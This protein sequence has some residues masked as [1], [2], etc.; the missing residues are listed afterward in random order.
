MTKY[1]IKAKSNERKTW[2]TTYD[3]ERYLDVKTQYISYEN[4]LDDELIHFSKYDCDRSIPK[5]MD[6]LNITKKILF[7]AF[8]KLYQEIKVAQ[9]WICFRTI[10]ISLRVE[11]KW[12]DC[13]YGTRFCRIKQYQSI[14]TKRS[15]RYA[16][17]IGKDGVERYIFTKLNDITKIFRKK[18][19][20]FKTLDDDGLNVEP[21]YYVP[22]IPMVLVNGALGIGTGFSMT[23]P[24]YNHKQIA[25]VYA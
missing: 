18:M 12:C 13:K 24:C 17:T 5:L 25:N 1:S 6:G 15:I 10:W 23:I 20:G 14:V 22:I 3:R 16:F 8:K 11:F 2:L 21:I 4:F 19:V 9:L 7:S